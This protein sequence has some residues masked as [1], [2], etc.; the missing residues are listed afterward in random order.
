MPNLG[1][2]FGKLGKIFR[3]GDKDLP[4]T[5]RV[6][7]EQKAEMKQVGRF[8]KFN[9]KAALSKMAE[10][11]KSLWRRKLLLGIVV[12]SFL[13]FSVALF[14]AT[15]PKLKE[16]VISEGTQTVENL[17]ISIPS[18][19]FPYD[20]SF[21]V[22][23]P[24]QSE[25]Q[26]II[27]TGNFISPIYELIPSDGRYDMAVLPIVVRHYFSSSLIG[28]NDSNSIAF[29]A[30]SSDGSTYNVIPGSFI[31]KDNKGYYVEANFFIVPKWIG[32]VS[33]PGKTLDTGIVDI[34][35]T[36]SAKPTLLI[37]P[38][39]EPN[40]SGYFQSTKV[41]GVSL[42]QSV[43]EDRSIA[44]YKYPVNESRSYNYTSA[45]K[46]FKESN[47][48]PSP[49]I[50]EAERLAQELKKYQQTQVDI[51]AH[52]IGGLI[53]Y[54]CLAKHPEIK[55]VRKVAY[56]ST[57][58]YGTNIVDPRL[59]ISLYPSRPGP[60]GMLFNLPG[61]V[62]S[63]M[64][65]YLKSYIEAVNVY[66]F[67]LIPNSE[68]L[69]ELRYLP[70]RTDIESIAYMG[71]MPPMSID[72]TASLL[73]RFY[74][75][76]VINLGDGLVSKSTARLPYMTL[77]I[78]NGSWSN[79]YTTDEFVQ[80]LKRYFEYELPDIPAY[81]DDTFSEKVSGEKEKIFER[82]LTGEKAQQFEV[83]EWKISDNPY[84]KFIQSFNFPG[85]QIAVYGGIIYTADESG[86][87]VSGTKVWE[88]MIINLK[89]TID[90]ISYGTQTK[91]YHRKLADVLT[92]QQSSADDFIS[93][94][95]FVIFAK[96]R[97]NEKVD[98][99]DETGNL[100]ITLRGIYGKVIYDGDE[101][102]LMTN[103]EIYRY[104]YGIKYTAPV[105]LYRSYDMTYAIVVD[106]YVI[107]TTRAY[108][109]IVFNR[110][111]NYTYVGEGWIGNMGLYET[112]N[113]IVAVGDN[114][115]TL[116]DFGKKRIDRIVENI[117]AT[118]YDATVWEDKL[119]I[120]TSEGV[121]IYKI[122]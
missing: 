110:A 100:I 75:E 92:Y 85:T 37:V 29:A 33:M 102:I 96:P 36:I 97:P 107:A 67:D 88:E 103:R 91:V 38:G 112:G 73:E 77:K 120:M 81:E 78:F 20:K 10:L 98:F 54:Y 95:D 113:Y 22:R 25:L 69:K 32:V 70:Y 93:T 23:I 115:I 89:E 4:N 72:V 12:L 42:W 28:S 19:A 49:I 39:S 114:F 62:I 31:D 56:V 82:F 118:V 65:A 47:P 46:L 21:R 48:L 50:F 41:P 90:G 63:S 99:I 6:L 68:F 122:G 111:G 80:E 94:K 84:V 74:P 7:Q 8:D 15:R 66:Y 34:Y 9:L 11:F 3:K 108:G 109:L 119:Y 24:N 14:F 44:L 58:F 30:I 79:F 87:Y 17:V 71:N 45:F 43:F 117:P 13:L 2:L 64:Q 86:L 57:P 83:D 105:G 76:L 16:T 26:K 104:Y 55:N 101:I 1:D 106:D 53:V 51:L 35:K 18:G 60:A 61:S 59:A 40:F 5:K 116:I 27:N 121:F 52:E